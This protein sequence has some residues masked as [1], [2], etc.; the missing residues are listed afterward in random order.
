MKRTSK[1][2]LSLFMA[3]I[4]MFGAALIGALVGFDFLN[5]FEIKASAANYSGTC[6]ENL[7]WSLDDETGELV[8]SGT[9]NMPSSYYYSAPWRSISSSIEKVIIGDSVKNIASD[10]FEW[11]E[12]LTSVTIGNGVTSIGDSA[13]EHCDSLTNVIIGD[14]VKNIASDAFYECNS[15]TDVYY[16]GD[17]AGWCGI[18]FSDYPANPMHYADNLYIDGNLL[19]GD[20]VIPDTVKSIAPYAFYNCKSLTSV[21]IPDSVTNI[22]Y[23]AFCSCDW[24]TNIT[25]GNSVTSIG[26]RAFFYCSRIKNIT[27]PDSVTSIGENAFTSRDITNVFI[28]ESVTNIGKRAFGGASIEVSKSNTVYSSDEYGVLFNKEK[29]QIIAYPYTN[30]RTSY[31]IPNSVISI[32][33]EAFVSCSLTSIV[34]PDTVTYIGDEAFADCSLTSIVIPDTVTYIGDAAFIFCEDMTYVHLP[35]MFSYRLPVYNGRHIFYG[36]PAYLCSESVD[37]LAQWYAEKY[38]VRFMVCDGSHGVLATINFTTSNGDKEPFHGSVDVTY[39]DKWFEESNEEYNHELG[40]FCADGVMLGYCY[41]ETKIE[42]YLSQLGFKNVSSGMNTFRDEVNYFIA[43]KD[44]MVNGKTETLVFASFIGSY[45]K[46]WNSNFDPWGLKRENFYADGSQKDSVHIGFADARDFAYGK[47]TEYFDKYEIKRDGTRLLLSGH[48][49]GAATANLLGKKIAEGSLFVEDD[50]L[51]VYTFATP[52][53]A[54]PEIQNTSGRYP[55]IFNIVN[56]EDF[57]T[58]VML[59]NWGY[60]RYGTTYVLPSK[61]NSDDYKSKY[62]NP[63]KVYVEKFK[64]GDTYKPYLNGEKT[65]NDLITKVYS[66]ISSPSVY[67]YNCFPLLLG[68]MTPFDFFQNALCPFVNGSGDMLSAG[69]LMLSGLKAD[70]YKSVAEFFLVNQGAGSFTGDVLL[71][72]YFAESHEMQTYAAYMHSMTEDQLKT[73]RYG[74]KGSVNCPVDV[75]IYDKDTNELVG[76]ITNNKVDETV[77]AGENSVVMS[78]DG[79]SKSF[80]LP[81]DGNYEVVLTGNDDGTMDYSLS[82]VDSDIGETERANFF[83]VV[84]EDGVSMNADVNGENFSIDEYT[85][86]HEKGGEI[87][88]TEI[89]SDNDIIAYTISCTAEGDGMVADS[90]SVVSGEYVT[91]F[92]VPNGTNRFLG[93][94]ENGVLVSTDS[95]YSFVAKED[96]ELEAVFTTIESVT[97]SKM[98]EKTEYIYKQDDINLAGMEIEVIYSDGSKDVFDDTSKMTAYGFSNEKRGEQTVTVECEG[99][100]ISFN[101]NVK[102]TWWQW[103]LVILLFGWIWY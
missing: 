45:K 72:E 91:V 80:W 66:Y 22:G 56:P 42:S 11:C 43:S 83:D 41:D 19:S 36:T 65:V 30:T 29:T 76:K 74:Y 62:L 20:V 21:T 82:V 10:A 69:A 4:M 13:F 81:S 59:T 100:Q 75:E 102:Y 85:L 101:V 9:G 52:N 71:D 63:M 58:K 27:I 68:D 40:R 51:Y 49:R 44:I 7:T 48:S 46:Q 88:A 90:L 79:D 50:N 25:I 1:K 87:E 38:R 98:P 18:N 35:K 64:E 17:L 24:L 37:S 8:I 39:K 2:I 31:T 67:Y 97:V 53:V 61:T 14:S 28:P 47:L 5:L 16:T 54:I 77:A 73:K 93:W 57:V 3:L 95:D 70:P 32:G 103:I 89:F 6:G 34:I 33:D 23:D 78:V 55:Q 26:D 60:S 84:I 15:L 92:A 86:D 99:L 94:Y 96:R 12:N